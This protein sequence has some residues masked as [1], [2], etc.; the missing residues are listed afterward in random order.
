FDI[1]QKRLSGETRPLQLPS[2]PKRLL[3]QTFTEFCQWAIAIKQLELP[4]PQ[5]GEEQ[6]LLQEA[7]Q[8]LLTIRQLELLQQ[9]LKRPLELWLILDRVMYLE[10][11]GFECQLSHY[12]D[13]ATSPRNFLIQAQARQSTEAR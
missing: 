2:F 7:E 6:G 4:L 3:S 12:C 8:K 9:P 10:E 11:H 13:R 5:S 1:H